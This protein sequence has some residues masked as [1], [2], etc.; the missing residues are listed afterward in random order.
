MQVSSMQLAGKAQAGMQCAHAISE[1]APSNTFLSAHNGR[2][3]QNP[4]TCTS[5]RRVV[6]PN[7]IAFRAGEGK[8]AR[9]FGPPQAKKTFGARRFQTHFFTVVKP[10]YQ[11]RSPN[12][13]KPER[14]LLR[15]HDPVAGP[16]RETV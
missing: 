12:T 13:R 10:R 1:P 2:A 6:L 9:F 7:S 15:N 8:S 3:T 14:T 11:S 4:N 16:R 5:V